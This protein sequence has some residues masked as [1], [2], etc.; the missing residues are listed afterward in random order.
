MSTSETGAHLACDLGHRGEVPQARV[1]RAAGPQQLGSLAASQVTHLIEV[2][3]AGVLAHAVLDRLEVATRDGHVPAVGQVAAHGQRQAHDLVA[4]LEE[5]EVDGQVGRRAGVG[6]HVG[7]VRAEER[8][9]AF[10][11]QGLERVHELLAFVVTLAGVAFAVLVREDRASGLEDGARDVVFRGN[12]PDLLGL[13]TLL[14]AHQFLYLGVGH[15]QR[16][17]DELHG[18]ASYSGG[19]RESTP[20]PA[21]FWSTTKQLDGPPADNRSVRQRHSRRLEHESDLSTG[22]HNRSFLRPVPLPAFGV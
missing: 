8:T 11:G 20:A 15:R 12:Q 7:V 10:L 17:I 5:G 21:S 1:G 16:F 22:S 14:G 13:A 6:L 3:T 18:P 4:R 19:A 2:D 9:G